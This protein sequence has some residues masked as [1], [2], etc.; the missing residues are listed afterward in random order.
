MRVLVLIIAVLALI[1]GLA[2]L[3]GG[4]L[5]LFS[6]LAMMTAPFP[7]EVA[8]A[9]E[10]S[11]LRIGVNFLIIAALM[12]FNGLLFTIFAI[13]AFARK[14]WAQFLG[15]FAYGLNILVSVMTF[16]LATVEGSKIPY[17]VGTLV[18]LTFIVILLF[19]KSAFQKPVPAFVNNRAVM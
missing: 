12:F 16:A 10:M 4:V 3:V 7:E 13:G 6:G 5:G 8:K 15:I 2:Y 19:S 11:P 1:G 14:R 9:S 18:A 17:I